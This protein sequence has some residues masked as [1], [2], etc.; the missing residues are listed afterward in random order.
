MFV[1]Y[2]SSKKWCRYNHPPTQKFFV[3]ID[4]IFVKKDSYFFQPYLEGKFIFENK[5]TK[6][7]T[8]FTLPLLLYTQIPSPSPPEN[9]QKAP[10]THPLKIHLIP[11]SLIYTKKKNLT[12]KQKKV[13]ASDTSF[14]T[15]VSL[16]NSI[17][18]DNNNTYCNL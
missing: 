18:S 10:K 13:Q 15:K 17:Q 7:F 14:E 4:I 3:F 2:Y 11:G 8:D 9:L 6:L 16:E 12:S 5:D 1:E